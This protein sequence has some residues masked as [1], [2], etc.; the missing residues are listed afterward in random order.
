MKSIDLRSDTVTVPTKEMLESIQYAKLGDDVEK[1]DETVNQLQEKAAKMFGA[2]A[3]M[4]VPSGTQSNLVAMLTHCKRGDEIILESEAHMYYYE[5]GGMASLVGAIPRLI[6]GTRGVFSAEDV[7]GA[8]RA[9][10]PLHYPPCRLL[11]VENTHN[12]AGGCCWTPAQVASVSKVAK[13]HGLSVHIDGA[14]IFNAAVALD[15]SVKDYMKSVDTINCCLSKG[16]C[17]PVGS[18]LIGTNEFIERAKI[19]RKM[20][21]GGMRQAGIIA[22]PGIVALDKMVSRLKEDHDN[23]KTLAK[24]L[25]K[26]NGIDIDMASV[27]TNIVIANIKGTGMNSDEYVEMCAKNG[28]RIFSFGPETVRFVTHHGI[29]KSDI[30]DVL[31]RLDGTS[32]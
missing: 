17:C 4:L 16:L 2:E 13:D 22:A 8:I 32:V 29:G 25:S 11:E 18:L 7:E 10:D 12:R 1:E 14:R 26:V 21:G 24:G 23:A 19:N 6:R 28:I 3:S 30:Q 15:V 27:Q 20:V 5:V 9:Y 31:S